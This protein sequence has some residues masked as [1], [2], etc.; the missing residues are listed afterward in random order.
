MKPTSLSYELPA[1]PPRGP[2]PT[3]SSA[4]P[5]SYQT[6]GV[7][8]TQTFNP[9]LTLIK[10]AERQETH[11]PTVWEGKPEDRERKDTHTTVS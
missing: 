4:P 1:H 6:G 11:L 3:P 10:Q 7:I 9:Q 2:P 5:K 8:T